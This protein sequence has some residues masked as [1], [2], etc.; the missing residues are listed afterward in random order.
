MGTNCSSCWTTSTTR[1]TGKQNFYMCY[2]PEEAARVVAEEDEK[3]AARGGGKKKA[4]SGPAPP[5]IPRRLST[6]TLCDGSDI[7]S[8]FRDARACRCGVGED[9]PRFNWMERS[10]H[11]ARAC[12]CEGRDHHAHA[13]PK[14][15]WMCQFLRSALG[16]DGAPKVAIVPIFP[17]DSAL[18]EFERAFGCLH[19][20]ADIS[21]STRISQ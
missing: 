15:T 13:Y 7:L 3:A 18:T 10:F 4:A 6:S 21:S 16:S 17:D 9:S 14:Y 5:A 8:L 11:H 19:Y 2:K 1:S 20:T 12:L